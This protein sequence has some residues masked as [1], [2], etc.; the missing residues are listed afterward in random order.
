MDLSLHVTKRAFNLSG[1]NRR[2]LMVAMAMMREP[3]L[4]FLDEPSAGMD[5]MARRFM[6]TVIQNI[7]STRKKSSVVLTTHSMEE[8]EALC[9]RT[10]IMVNGV[11]RCLGAHTHIKQKYGQGYSI[12]VKTRNPTSEQIDAVLV[13]WGLQNERADKRVTLKFLKDMIR[14]K[15]DEWI[16]RAFDTS[17]A[18]FEK[19]VL[20]ANLQDAEKKGAITRFE[21]S[22]TTGIRVAANFLVIARGMQRVA[23]TLRTVLPNT[24]WLEWHGQSANYQVPRETLDKKGWGLGPVFGLFESQKVDLNIEEYAVSQTTLEEVFARFAKDQ[25]SSDVSGK[26]SAEGAA[27][28]PSTQILQELFEFVSPVTPVTPV[29]PQPNPA[30]VETE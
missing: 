10:V 9:T 16:T 14:G 5:P 15:G 13:E 8:C 3:P 21:C 1:G 4:I 28:D 6:W 7:A 29:V 30:V 17:A 25:I 12:T 23:D 26:A 22:Q 19:M 20:K 24:L 11:F 2:K 27:P 18:P